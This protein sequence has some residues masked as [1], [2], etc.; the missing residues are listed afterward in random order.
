MWRPVVV[1][2]L[3]LEGFGEGWGR[4]VYLSLGRTRF[5]VQL[6]GEKMSN[7]IVVNKPHRAVG[8]REIEEYIA[9]IQSQPVDFLAAE[10][11]I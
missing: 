4:S 8:V 9:A 2:I 5:A 7:R 11:E 10:Y 6:Q 3:C 1:P